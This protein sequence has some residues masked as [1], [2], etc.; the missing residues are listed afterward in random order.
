MRILMVSRSWPADERSGVSLAAHKH[1]KMLIDAGHELHIMGSHAAIE[2]ETLNAKKYYIPS[3]GSGALY[4]PAKVDKQLLSRTISNIQP[5]LIILEAWQTALTESVIDIAYD[6]H[7]PSLMISHGMSI[8]PYT[9]SLRHWIRYLAWL[10]YRWLCLPARMKKL[11]AMTALDL[12]VQSPRFYDRDCAQNL[13]TPVFELTNSPALKA[14]PIKSRF[15]RKDQILVVG[16]FSEVKNQLRAL[17]ILNELPRSI[18]MMLVGKKEGMYY[19]RCLVYVKK[20]HLETRVGFCEDHEIDLAKEFCESTLVLQTS[21]TE[22]LPITLLE[23]MVTGTPFV[24]TT[25]GAVSALQGGI[26]ADELSIQVRAI[27]QLFGDPL[28]WG[29]LAANGRAD[30]ERRFTDARVKEQLCSAVD[31]TI[32]V[33]LKG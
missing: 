1:A 16:Y 10:P 5:D 11:S 12:H 32:D 14:L 17:T 4:A 8:H 33:A 22:V 23:A 20:H 27:N 24:A 26:H 30:F 21:I 9:H 19:Q 13:N 15:E 28:L 18:S 2:Q 3:D 29:Q 31:K 6:Q 7:I 25:V